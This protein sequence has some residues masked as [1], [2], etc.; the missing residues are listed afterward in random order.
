MIITRVRVSPQE[1]NVSLCN[2]LW[3]DETWL[4]VCVCVCVC[5]CFGVFNEAVKQTFGIG[6]PLQQIHQNRLMSH[7]LA[8]SPHTH[9]HTHTHT[10]LGCMSCE[11][12]SKHSLQRLLQSPTLY[13]ENTGCSF[14]KEHTGRWMAGRGDH[15]TEPII[16]PPTRCHRTTSWGRISFRNTLFIC[17]IS[18][19]AETPS[20]KWW[21]QCE[22]TD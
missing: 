11:C 21:E 12:M 9:T 2:V 13:T 6:H 8:P 10:H 22:I 5:V 3:S 1:I 19:G 14:I 4:C 17:F 20:W 18:K 7:Q 16:L 15:T